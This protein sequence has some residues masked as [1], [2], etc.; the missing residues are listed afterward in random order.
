MEKE[1]N[2]S[3]ISVSDTWDL[4]KIYA[5][6]DDFE[7]DFKRIDDLVNEVV[8]FKGKIMESS[9]SLY[10]F[11]IAYEKM[12]RMLMKLFMY[13][14]L[15]KDVDTTNSKSQ[16]LKMRVL[17]KNEDISS[18]TSFIS[19]E[20]LSVDYDLV[21]SYIKENK[22]L[23]KYAFDLEKMFRY[24][25]HTLSEKEEAIITEATNA[26]GTGSDA[27][28]YIDNT[29]I[30]LGKIKDE[31]GNMVELT[32]SNYIKYMS[33]SDRSVR[34]AAFNSMYN[35]FKGLK[36]TISA[37]LKGNIKENFFLS[38]VK[39]YSSPLEA[40]M[41][42]DNIDVSVYKNLISS[43]HDNLDT[44]YEYLSLRKKILKLDEMHMYDIYVDLV[45]INNDDIPFEKG[46]E[47]VFSALKPL[48]DKYINDLKKAFDERWIDKYPNKGKKSGAYSWGS[49]DTYPYLLLNYNNTPDSVVTMAH[50]LGHSMHSYYSDKNQ[51][52]FNS[53][54]PIFLAEIAS[55]VNEVLLNDYM[56]KNAKNKDEK[57]FYIVEMIDKIRSTIYRQ[58]MFAEFEMIMHNKEFD[59]VPLTEEEF[60]NTYYSL[61]KLYYGDNVV[62]DDLI[63]YEWARI[64][65]FYTSFYVYKYATGLAAAL[66]IATDILSGKDKARDAYLEFLSSGCSDYPLNILKKVGVDMTT[67]EP[68]EKALNFFKDKVEEL[69]EL[70]EK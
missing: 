21:L 39:K 4:T 11:Y 40:S 29:D 35:Y 69:K 27:F 34:I 20:M 66:A 49:Y 41:Y 52:Y 17:K 23:E 63:R 44:M 70:V 26:F 43:I 31:S 68:I 36:N 12:D 9:D 19:S 46:K 38:K 55:T 25:D 59:G 1:K 61:N 7:K 47:I 24:K 60:S 18:A 10:N 57:I 64:P 65:H 6:S 5:S 45:K 56:Y 14:S 32:N 58:T 13:A 15:N 67:K 16:A 8:S 33:S 2:R 42:S 51:N 53:Q 3:E 62:S 22:N 30:N 50:E 28:N 54:Y 48:G 37:C